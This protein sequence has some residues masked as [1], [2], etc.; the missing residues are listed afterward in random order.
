MFRKALRYLGIGIIVIAA[1]LFAGEFIA[2]GYE[3]PPVT[4]LQW[5]ILFLGIILIAASAD[6]TKLTEQHLPH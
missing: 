5:L 1:T 2:S 6:R 4:G 3:F